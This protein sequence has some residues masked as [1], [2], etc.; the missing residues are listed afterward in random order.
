MSLILIVSVAIRVAAL[1]WSLV[2]LKRL[3]DWRIA[4]FSA[5]IALMALRQTLTLLDAPEPWPIAVTA[6]LDELPGLA[7]SVL[8]FLALVFLGRMIHEREQTARELREKGAELERRVAD[9]ER[10]E[11]ARRE[12]ERVLATLMGNLPG[13]VYRCR[14]DPDWTLEFCSE[15]CM[16]LTGYAPSDFVDQVASFGD[17][18]HADDRARVWDEV[19]AALNEG[20]PY[21]LTY[22]IRTAAGE[23]KWVWEHGCGVPAPGSDVALEGFITDVT[24]QRRMQEQLH[25]AR[26]MEAIGQLSGG[27]AHDFNNLL[28]V[29]IGNLELC[30][31]KLGDDE[32]LRGHVDRA[33]TAAE[34][35]ATLTEQ[36]LA[37]SRKQLLWPQPVNLNLLASGMLELLRRTLGEEIEVE[38][39]FAEDLWEPLV[40]PNQL[41]NV[42]INLALNARDAMEG[43]GTLTIQ[44]ANEVVSAGAEAPDGLEAG[45]YVMLAVHDTGKGMPPEVAERAFEPFFT[46]K[47]AA[48]GLGLSMVYGFAKQLGGHARITSE[49]GRGTTVSLY[50]P[51]AR[52]QAAGPGHGSGS[53][54]PER[55]SGK[56]IRLID[57][58]PETRGLA[59]HTLGEPGCGWRRRRTGARPSQFWRTGRG[60]A[61]SSRV[62]RVAPG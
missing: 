39:D 36:L 16:G 5:M 20:R 1:S 7:V 50:L 35:G 3:G 22:R 40:D 55:G 48:S 44:T 56:T 30:A 57:D 8:V 10:A 47:E 58:L 54:P 27:V 19:Q 53:K 23:E 18:I 9:F 21:Q 42:L 59:R 15:G 26:K 12:S 33:L 41:E 46:T 49:A 25:G 34:R 14:N 32:T 45:E 31:E 2:L 51:R 61:F 60:S 6:N 24:E 52:C 29:I 13:M 38:T 28:S 43:G 62:S 11:E 37:F 17:L 4:F